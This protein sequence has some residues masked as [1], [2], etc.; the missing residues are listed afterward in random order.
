M[1]KPI[2][3]KILDARVGKDFPLPA[4]ATEGLPVWIYVHALMPLMIAPGPNGTDPNRS[5]NAYQRSK[6]MCNY[7]ARSG[8]GHRYRIVLGN[9]VGL[10]DAF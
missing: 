3:V 7:F 1:K 2:E 5:C 4:Y 6:S 8:L 9:L 10:I